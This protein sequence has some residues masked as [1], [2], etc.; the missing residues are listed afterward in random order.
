MVFQNTIIRRLVY[1]GSPVIFDP[2]PVDRKRGTFVS[3]SIASHGRNVFY[4]SEEGF[5]LFNG[6]ESIPIGDGRVDRTFANQFDPSQKRSVTAAIDDK[7]KIYA[8]AFPGA[9]ATGG[10]PNKLYLC[11]W[12]G[13]KWADVDIEIEV[14]SRTF[15]QGFTLDGLD[16]LGTDIDDSAVFDE[17]FDS[18]KWKGNQFRFGAFDMDHKL[19]FFTGSNLAATFTTRE[20]Q[21][22]QGRRSMVSS[23]RP[24]VDGGTVTCAIGHREA[25]TD[26]VTFDTAASQDASGRCAVRNSNRYHRAR[27]TIAAGGTWEHAQGIQFQAAPKGAK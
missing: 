15:T 23:I 14:L 3:G 12:P 2:Q 22:F 6:L 26:S 7:N 13:N 9:G 27:M 16:A 20:R 21:L 11:Y 1:T 8:I 18:D 17:S 24:L 19:G 25:L 5:H 4:W 10:I